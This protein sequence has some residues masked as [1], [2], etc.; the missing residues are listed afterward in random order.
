MRV[1]NYV[2]DI[3]G[4]TARVKVLRTLSLYP[5]KDVTGRELASMTGSAAYEPIRRAVKQLETAGI[6]TVRA[7]G[8]AYVIRLNEKCEAYGP[9]MELFRGEG[10][11]WKHFLKGLRRL[12]PTEATRCLLFGSVARGDEKAGSDVDLL[13]VVSDVAAKRRLHDGLASFYDAY[14]L[15][16]SWHLV[17]EAELRRDMPLLRN[18]RKRYELIKG[19][20][21][22]RV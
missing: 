19:R 8:N 11:S 14:C 22:W 12:V 15:P 13:L 7:H 17:T 20:D 2:D 18:V 1:R 6:V 16:L 10:E 5:W 3:L 4:S 9:L 21:P